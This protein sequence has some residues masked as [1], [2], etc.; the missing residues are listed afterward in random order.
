MSRE[1]LEKSLGTIAKSGTT[2]FLA[3]L[4]KNAGKD[5]KKKDVNLIGQ[6]GVGF[7]PRFW[8]PI[9]VRFLGK[10]WVQ[11]KQKKTD[12]LRPLNPSHLRLS[13]LLSASSERSGARSPRVGLRTRWKNLSSTNSCKCS[14]IKFEQSLRRFYPTTLKRAN[15]RDHNDHKPPQRP[16]PCAPGK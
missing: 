7:I 9:R 11:E 10:G 8:L 6:F 3:E 15:K 5:K 16:K 12:R 4:E 14:P 2:E 13:A 1:E